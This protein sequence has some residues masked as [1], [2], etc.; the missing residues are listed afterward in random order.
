M[1]I[2]PV[3][4]GSRRQTGNQAL[5]AETLSS[6]KILRAALDL[7]GALQRDMPSHA[8]ERA[9]ALCNIILGEVDAVRGLETTALIGG[10]HG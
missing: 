4:D 6:N 2:T 1:Q 8:I 5:P 7:K 10:A 9:N 3:P